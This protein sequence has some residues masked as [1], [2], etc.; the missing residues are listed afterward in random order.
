[1]ESAGAPVVRRR[2]ERRRGSIKS[3]IVEL[4]KVS[5]S[6][7]YRVVSLLSAHSNLKAISRYL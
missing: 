4:S 2:G 6:S 7:E 5:Y 1:M 3:R